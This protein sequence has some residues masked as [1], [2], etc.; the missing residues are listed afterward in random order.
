MNRQE[1]S[2]APLSALKPSPENDK[3]YKP[4][5]PNDPAIREL[6]DSICKHGLLEPLVITLDDYILS[7]HRRHAAA[8]V[9]GLNVVPVRREPIFRNDDPDAFVRK[10][11]EYNRQRDKTLPEKLREELVSTDPD[12]AYQSLLDHREDAARVETPA[13]TIQGEVKRRKIS[14]AKTPFLKAALR[15]AEER[16]AYWPLSVRQIHYALLNDPPLKHASKPKSRYDNSDSSYKALVELL[17]RARVAGLFPWESITDET[18]PVSIWDVFPTPQQFVGKENRNYLK[19]YHRDLQQSQPNHIEVLGE[20]NTVGSILKPVAGEF[21]IPLTIGRGF[22]SLHP[23]K[24]MAQ[25]FWKSG[26]EKLIVLICSDHDPDGEEIAQSFARSMRD[27]FGI[28]QIHPVKVALTREQALELN[29]PNALPAKANSTNFKKFL[30]QFGNHGWELESLTPEQ[31]KGLLRE[32]ILSVMDLDAY[33][34]EVELEKQD[35]AFL[36]SV[37]RT[38][39]G[40]LS[41]VK[42]DDDPGDN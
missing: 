17:A 39:T 30:A 19:G 22:C 4:V 36:Q 24:E 10:L 37:R 20:K 16:R 42:L 35:A 8:T 23:R 28:E 1:V 14:K 34:A 5:D 6:A 7:G 31:L 32:A 15:V 13:F 2:Q 38:I 9:A 12:D 41:E 27:D 33:N 26:R 11:R 40:A 25:R 3:L 18:R 29:L 21:C